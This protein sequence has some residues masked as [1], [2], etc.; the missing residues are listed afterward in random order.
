MAQKSIKGTQTEKNLVKSYLAESSA[1][2][3]YTF[4]AAQAKKENYF[5]IQKVFED[6]ADNELHHAKVFF[7]FLEGGKV[8]VEMGDVD[9]GVIGDTATNLAIAASEEQAEGVVAYTDAAAVADSEGFPE[10]AAHFRAIA[11]IEKRH[12][13]RFKT[14]LQQVKDGTVW[15]RDHA[16]TWQCMVCG[17]EYVGTEPPTVCPACDHPYQHYRPLDLDI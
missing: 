4:Y 13:A 15:K 10:I 9:A 16:I 6:T 7:K 8:T 5:P 12:E 1:Y 2:S 17:F 3:R 11:E 14:L